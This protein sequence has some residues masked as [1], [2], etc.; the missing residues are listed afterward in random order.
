MLNA[1][2]AAIISRLEAS[3]RTRPPLVQTITLSPVISSVPSSDASVA[4]NGLSSGTSSDSV[5][6]P[7]SSRITSVPSM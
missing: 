2:K 5:M 6:P 4:F 7:I 3:G 1:N